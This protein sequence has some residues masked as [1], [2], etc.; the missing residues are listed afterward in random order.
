MDDVAFAAMGHR[1]RSTLE[2]QCKV[3]LRHTEFEDRESGGSLLRVRNTQNTSG[4][5]I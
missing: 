4:L 5:E 1:M 3:C 2:G